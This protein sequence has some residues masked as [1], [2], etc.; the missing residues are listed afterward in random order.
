MFY[1]CGTYP[2]LPAKSAFEDLVNRDGPATDDSYTPLQGLRSQLI[3]AGSYKNAVF[4]LEKF[5]DSAHETY[6]D[7]Q[8]SK[9]IQKAA[10]TPGVY[11]S[12]D[13]VTDQRYI[14]SVKDYEEAVHNFIV[15]NLLYSYNLYSGSSK[16][17]DLAFVEVGALDKDDGALVYSTELD[18][19]ST[20]E[21]AYTGVEDTI[22]AVEKL[23]YLTIRCFRH[24]RK[25]RVNLFTMYQRY[26]EVH[27]NK[28]ICTS[29][30]FSDVS[31]WLLDKAG[32]AV[33][34]IEPSKDQKGDYFPAAREIFISPERPE[35]QI[36]IRDFNTFAATLASLD[37]NV[38][39]LNFD[40]IRAEL[41]S[42]IRSSYVPTNS[43]Y[44]SESKD[45]LIGMLG[46]Y[47]KPNSLL[48]PLANFN[49]EHQLKTGTIIRTL[50]KADELT[51]DNLNFIQE[52]LVEWYNPEQ[53]LLDLVVQE[54]A[55]E[56]FLKSFFASKGLPVN[57]VE[58]GNLSFDEYLVYIKSLNSYAVFTGLD[59]KIT[60]RGSFDFAC[61]LDITGRFWVKSGDQLYYSSLKQVESCLNKS[62]EPEWEA[63]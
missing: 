3:T 37:L 23:K 11:S 47:F 20:Y 10:K 50:G 7:L 22:H 48:Q 42:C 49:S 31:P 27:N 19:D 53:R 52:Q 62:K 44:L 55:V 57:K 5:L 21:E 30:T 28:S 4:S 43:E 60:Y 33:R 41:V 40:A 56:R 2:K 29:R 6:K 32:K 13:A 46:V 34:I 1:N 54:E 12:S 38:L 17:K 18:V 25:Y 36:I 45:Q 24:C 16:S 26:Y 61:V 58:R 14:E 9:I 8:P 63:V 15:N 59:L 39:D 35:H 51:E